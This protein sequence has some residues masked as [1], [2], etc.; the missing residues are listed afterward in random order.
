MRRVL[1]EELVE[2]QQDFY[3]HLLSG[4]TRFV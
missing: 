1:F 4:D 2:G 3:M